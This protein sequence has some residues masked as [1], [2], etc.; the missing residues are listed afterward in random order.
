[1]RRKERRQGVAGPMVVR[2]EMMRLTQTM[3]RHDKRVETLGCVM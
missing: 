3:M 1:M 2:M